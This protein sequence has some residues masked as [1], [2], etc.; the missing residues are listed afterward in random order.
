MD[1]L[2]LIGQVTGTHRLLGTVK[3]NS[4]FPNVESLKGLSVILK[5][6]ND[7]KISKI[8][9]VKGITGGRVLFDLDKINN[10]DLAKELGGYKIYVRSD[11]V[12]DYEEEISI[13]GYN[14]Y[15]KEEH[16]GEVIDI[17]ETA[18]HEIL[19]V[20][21]FG[22]EIMIP[23]IDVFVKEVDDVKKIIKVELIEGM[24]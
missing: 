5:K 23:Y 11:L 22:S 18:A 15:D 20:D 14:V 12:P 2:I 7:I 6:D 1:N 9:D 16:I 4:K 13:I 8:N 17:L 19:I 10:L 3:V 21:N 24:R